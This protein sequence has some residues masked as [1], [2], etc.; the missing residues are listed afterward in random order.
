MN[1]QQHVLLVEDSH[2]QALN[3]GHVLEQAECRVDWAPTVEAAMEQLNQTS[4][5][6][7]VL[8][9]YLP[10]IPGDELCR[11]IRMNIDT[12]NIPILMLTTDAT[13]DAE[14]RGL[15]S[16]A[17][18]FVP[19]S[20]D[21]AVLL[22]RVRTLLHRSASQVSIP[23]LVEQRFRRA[24]LLTIDDSPTY[25][26]YLIGELEHEGYQI[27]KAMCGTE[28]LEK[29]LRE[30]F[31]CALV[32]LVMPE[33]SG[34]EVCR[35]VRS[36]RRLDDSIALLMLTGQETKEDLTQALEAG[37]DD[38]V[39]KS[40][41]MAV[42]KGRIRALLRRKFCQE[43]NRRIVE[44]LKSKEVELVRARSEKAL[45][46]AQAALNAELEQRVEQRTAELANA[47]RDLAQ[48]T[49]ENEMF[50]YSVS[51]DLRSPLVNLQGFGGELKATCQELRKLLEES[52]LPPADKKRTLTLVD[53][54]MGMSIRFIQTAVLRLSKIVDALL[55]L[56]RAGRVEYQFQPVD[57]QP[58]VTRVIDSF[59]VT[60]AER[61]ATI[62]VG[63][64]P[65]VWGDP[66]AIER[67]IANL[68]GN[69]LNYLDPSRPGLIEIG[70]M[71][72]LAED[73]SDG[74]ASQRTIS[75]GDNGLGIPDAYRDKIFKIFQRLHPEIAGG[76]GIGLAIVLRAVG[77]HGGKVWFESREGQG[78][79]FFVSLPAPR[80]EP[81]SLPLAGAQ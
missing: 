41:D 15:E 12:R 24:R 19:K 54:D 80:E 53:D 56:S 5:D 20:A 63:D 3:L 29:L 2:T 71:L 14:L 30:P 13:H 23:G 79:T 58:L 35:Q 55:Q 60:I 65:V 21:P 49:R 70:S 59:S 10:G 73:A 77:R 75:I 33:M 1:P 76:E 47:N 17:D 6:L 43:D 34:I 52:S 39:G 50:V 48:Q 37:A 4:P 45:A 28:G 32:D 64:L 42:L 74:R 51:H 25:Q 7:I 27:E 31:D 61:G 36:L 8:D 18:D 72:S 67:V 38:F 22:A 57:V 40:S 9:Y 26:Q 68:I 16:G 62:Q 46:E 78:T 69:A 66:T 81:S 11:R 44:E